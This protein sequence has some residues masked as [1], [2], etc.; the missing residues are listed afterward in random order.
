MTPTEITKFLHASIPITA[1][2]GLRVQVFGPRHVRLEAPL[3]L[4]CNHHG[5]GFGGSLAMLG[6]LCGW[7]LAH[8]NLAGAGRE[9]VLVIQRS[10][11]DF[12][13]PARSDLLAETHAEAGDCEAFVEA[14]AAR[15]RARMDLRTEIRDAAGVVARHQA[16]YVALPAGGGVS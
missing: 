14:L 6:V 9:A 16:R 15:G 10:E 1:A 3:A 11:Q 12:V 8:A 13:A 4:N 7:T 5:T 2:A